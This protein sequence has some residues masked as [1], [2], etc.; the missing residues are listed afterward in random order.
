M[1][2]F[3]RKDTYIQN[4]PVF[5]RHHKTAPKPANESPPQVSTSEGSEDHIPGREKETV[6]WALFKGLQGAIGRLGEHL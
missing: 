6:P 4:N 2:P 5:S 3:T 1:Q